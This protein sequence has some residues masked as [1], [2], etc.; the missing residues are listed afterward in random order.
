MVQIYLYFV[1]SNM[2]IISM[3]TL[4]EFVLL[5]GWEKQI[6]HSNIKKTGHKY[7]WKRAMMTLFAKSWT[8]IKAKK[9]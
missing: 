6:E 5:G 8:P 2:P 7:G 4:Q 9:V 1:H 3:F